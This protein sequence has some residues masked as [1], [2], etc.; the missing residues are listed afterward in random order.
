MRAGQLMLA[1][2]ALLVAGVL[3]V[4]AADALRWSDAFREDDAALAAGRSPSW[5]ADAVVPGGAA[6]RTLAVD[7]DRALRQAILAYRGVAGRTNA[8]DPAALR[9]A[10]AEAEVTLADVVASGSPEQASQASNLLG[11]LLF[12][13]ATTNGALGRSTP[14]ERSVAAFE[15]AVTQQRSNVAAKYNL[16]LVLRLLEARGVRTGGTPAPGTRGSGQRGA[17]GGTPGRGY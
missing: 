11:I 10:R 7:D 14:V 1:G 15:S 8:L 17:G 9:R 4:L 5:Q 16:E 2:A 6:E 12:A 13:D 3:L